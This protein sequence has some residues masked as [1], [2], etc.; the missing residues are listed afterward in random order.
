MLDSLPTAEEVRIASRLRPEQV[1]S[2]LADVAA[3]EA[4]IDGRIEEQGAYVEM[5]I[6]Q[7][8]APEFWPFADG[9]LAAAY[10]AYDSTQIAAIEARQSSVAKQCVKLFS[11]ADL[12]DSAG[13]L[14]ERYQAEAD[15]Y[16]A[17]AE[18]LLT[19]LTGELE[20]Q[21]SQS[22]ADTENDGV[23]MLTI[24]VGEDFSTDENGC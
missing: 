20:W 8:A 11:L 22:G 1:S 18:A 2:T 3:L 14:N 9:V 10:P 7:S 15:S 12:Y 23:T 5:R 24:A 17:R 13:Q 16:R 6:A 19:Q 21:V 4:D